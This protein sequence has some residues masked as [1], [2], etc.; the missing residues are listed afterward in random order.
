M[1]GAI[2]REI[3]VGSA[4]RASGTETEMSPIPGNRYNRED[5]GMAT[6]EKHAIDVKV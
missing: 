6:T 1:P 5:A 3:P 2:H 4:S